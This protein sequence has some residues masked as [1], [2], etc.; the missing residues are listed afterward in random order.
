MITKKLILSLV[1]LIAA[2]SNLQ[3]HALW[4]QTAPTGAAGKEHQIKIVY[5]EPNQKPEKLSEWYSDVKEF[6]LWLTTPD[7]KQ[8][9]LTT[10]AG[11]DFFTSKFTPSQE[12]VY[13]LSIGHTAKEPGGTT[14]Y[15]FNASALVQV[16][17]SAASNNAKFT[18]N[19]LSVFA[20]ASKE[21]K[22][23]KPLILNT[24][25]KNAPG[26]KI[27]VTVSSP[28]GWAKQLETNAEGIAE[29]TPIWPG[30]Y[31][32]EASKSWNESGTQNGKEYKAVWR[33]ATLLVEVAK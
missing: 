14:V 9:K 21:Y 5:A 8:E 10:V 4:I 12:G 28:T 23:N 16:G 2:I 11:D 13:I 7:G 3:A 27:A 17:K 30:T 18:K 6:E 33:A 24:S 26:E 15:Q 19:D 31:Y 29:F 25:Y 1:I 20:N 32:I 22:V